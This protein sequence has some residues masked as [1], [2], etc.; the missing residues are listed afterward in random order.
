[1]QP[2]TLMLS[3]QC[4]QQ[5]INI[6]SAIHACLHIQPPLSFQYCRSFASCRTLHSCCVQYMACAQ[7]VVA[8]QACHQLLAP[9]ES[10][11]LQQHTDKQH[12]QYTHFVAQLQRRLHVSELLLHAWSDV[13]TCKPANPIVSMWKCTLGALTMHS[14]IAEHI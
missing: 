11:R 6:A 13:G 5:V 4:Q 14:V 8:R 1:M 2:H 12:S 9:A 10:I 3:K 7:T